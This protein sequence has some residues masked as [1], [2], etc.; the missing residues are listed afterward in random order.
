MGSKENKNELILKLHPQT[1]ENTMKAIAIQWSQTAKNKG[2][3]PKEALEELNIFIPCEVQN[4]W[5]LF[6]FLQFLNI[7][8]FQLQKIELVKEFESLS[9]KGE[10]NV[11]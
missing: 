2:K 11:K 3:C 7:D 1:L 9:N 10:K 8:N 5:A 4:D 6:N